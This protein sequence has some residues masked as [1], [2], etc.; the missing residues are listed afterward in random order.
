MKSGLGFVFESY[1]T[2]ELSSTLKRALDSYHK[3]KEWYTLMVRA[4]ETDYSWDKSI[5]KY[6]ALYRLA[7]GKT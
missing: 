4:M 5:S 2:N 6:E 7:K 3:R 1:N